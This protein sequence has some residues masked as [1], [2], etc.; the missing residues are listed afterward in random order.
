MNPNNHS[1]GGGHGW[2]G[3]L[4]MVACCIPMIVLFVYIGLK[5]T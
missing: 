4:A 5:A 3:T 1:H 2:R